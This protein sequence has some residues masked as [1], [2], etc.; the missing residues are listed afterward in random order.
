MIRTQLDALYT[1][2]NEYF[3]NHESNKEEIV[4]KTDTINNK[5]K[6]NKIKKYD[7]ILVNVGW[8]RHYG[9]IFKLT[10]DIAFCIPITSNTDSFD[11]FEIT[12]SRIF[13]G[14][15]T[16]QIV[17]VPVKDAINNFIMP[18]DSKKEVDDAIACM[19]EHYI[20]NKIF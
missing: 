1:F 20:K 18:Y 5:L 8:G 2:A 4:V 3:E 10:K 19:K 7:V 16:Y 14:V 6:P 11:S 17:Q 13:K 12:R 9:V 15:L